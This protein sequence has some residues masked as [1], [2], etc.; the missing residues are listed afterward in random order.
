MP[1]ALLL[2]FINVYFFLTYQETRNV[3]D[4]TSTVLTGLACDNQP[5]PTAHVEGYVDEVVPRYSDS[6][7]KDHFRMSRGL[8]EV[9]T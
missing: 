6:Q 2:S 1:A 3:L 8:F 4:A 7:F 5:D 9:Y